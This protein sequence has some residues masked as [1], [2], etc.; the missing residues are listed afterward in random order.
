MAY[1][2]NKYRKEYETYVKARRDNF[3][4][5][6]TGKVGADGSRWG[7]PKSSILAGS[8]FVNH[9][10]WGVYVEAPICIFMY[11]YIHTDMYTDIYIYI[12][13]IL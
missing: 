4:A 6:P 11:I 5:F 2:S 7:T 10:F 1:D 9:P 3:W 13:V 12:H 8:V